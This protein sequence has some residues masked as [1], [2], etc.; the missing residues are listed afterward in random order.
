MATWSLL[1]RAMAVLL[2]SLGT[3]VAQDKVVNVYNWTD[4]IDP[5]VLADFTKETGIKVVYD[6]Y[7]SNEVL[8]TKLMA[9]KTGYDVVVPTSYALARQLQAG[10]YRKLDKAKLT[11]LKHASPA[12]QQR[13]TR[14]DPGNEHA[15]VYMWGTTGIGYNE[16]KIEERMKNAPTGSLRMIFDPNVVKHFAD[17][18][19]N[20]L[21]DPADLFSAALKY[22]GLDPDSKKVEDLQ[23][24]EAALMAIR[25]Y[26]RKFHSS[27]YIEDLANGDTC[28]A[29]G[30][31]GDIVQAKTRAEEAKKGVE[32]VYKIPREG[33]QMWFDSFVMPKDAPHPDAAHAFINFML[34]PDIAARCTNA[35][36]YPNGNKDADKLVKAEIKE[37]AEIYPPA[38][39]LK[40]LY[41]ISPFPQRLQT[42]LNRMWTRVKD[43]K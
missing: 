40:T 5:T 27:Q 33:A 37:D 32:V 1:G 20:V 35:I 36:A 43:G 29:F 38:E 39:R 41:T 26:I 17:C 16:K 25:P 2:L 18:G 21:D 14:Y 3:A 7:D 9:G 10:V 12:I 30:F 19:V 23:K 42:Q 34:R 31:S 13:M 11:N 28:L 8:E 4:Y 15:V 6:T 22:L 24:A